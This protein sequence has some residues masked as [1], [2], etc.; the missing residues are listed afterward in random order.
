MLYISV[1][2]RTKRRMILL[3]SL[4]LL[5]LV[6][7]W[8]APGVSEGHL[9]VATGYAAI[10]R[11]ESTSRQVALTFNTAWGAK[12]F[13]AVCEVL[14]ETG[15][16]GTFFVAG[17][18]AEANPELVEQAAGSGHEIGSLGYRQIDLTAA[19]K[20][21]VR[22]ELDRALEALTAVL[23]ERPQLFRPPGGRCNEELTG[24][25]MDKGLVVVTAALDAQDWAN[26]GVEKI[27]QRVEEG[28]RPGFIIEFHADDSSAQ[29]AEAL[30]VIIQMLHENDYQLVT[31][32]QLL[33]EGGGG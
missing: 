20:Q 16:R 4:G 17:P 28:V 6:M 26:P 23:Q 22:E 8:G 9:P 19:E 13:T 31:V 32:S 27:A 5:L 15:V 1:R 7:H 33:G 21:V 14:E 25:A 2:P 11:V 3:S 29:L 12:T 10:D 30:P 24:V 18:W